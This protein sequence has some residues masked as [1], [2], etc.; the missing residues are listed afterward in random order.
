VPQA[1]ETSWAVFVGLAF[2][3]AA[4]SVHAGQAFCAIGRSETRAASIVA[5]H[6]SVGAI[7]VLLAIGLDLPTST[8]GAGL[9]LRAVLVAATLLALTVDAVFAF[10]AMRVLLADRILG[11]AAHSSE[12]EPYRADYR[13]CSKL[14]H[15]FVSLFMDPFMNDSIS[16]VQSKQES[17][18]NNYSHK[19]APRC[20]VPASS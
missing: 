2:G 4:A 18:F 14:L 5:A 10:V 7:S 15:R 16:I 11:L 19:T 9:P 20:K 13:E 3:L 1:I 6:L 12:G 17:M 8:G